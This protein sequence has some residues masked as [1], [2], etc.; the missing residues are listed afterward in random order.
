MKPR[1]LGITILSVL[2]FLNSAFFAVLAALSVVNHS[3]L[4]A[5]LWAISPGGAGP[6]VV[7]LSMG[8]PFELVYYCAMTLF[9]GLLAWGFW[10]LWNWTRVV[11]LVLI[12]V[13]LLGTA[14][15][16]FMMARGGS[17]A[18]GVAPMVRIFISTLISLLIGWYLL[19]AK[20]RAAFRPSV[21]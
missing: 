21:P 16:P 13:S 8:R 11:T 15:E 6:A 14:F 3:A 1:P 5:L 17:G 2:L 20:V 9:T 18:A 19:S 10:K 4:A 12:A 7:H